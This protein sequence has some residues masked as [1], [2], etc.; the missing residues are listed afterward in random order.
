MRSIIA[1]LTLAFGIGLGG[2]ATAQTTGLQPFGSEAELKIWLAD[3]AAQEPPVQADCPPDWEVC[4][5]NRIDEVVVT[6][7]RAPSPTI[8]NNQEAGVDEGDIVKL[9]GDTLVILR[10]GR[11]FTVD[12][13]QGGLRP[14]ESIAAYAPGVEA[15][16]DWYDEMLVADGWVVVIGYSYERETSEINRFRLD[17]RGRL[18]FVDSH[19]LT[20]NDYYSSRNYASRLI[21]NRLVLYSPM[22]IGRDYDLM[23]DAPRLTRLR[24]D[25]QE[26][27]QPLLDVGDIYRTPT[28]IAGEDPEAEV[29][30]TLV[31]CDLTARVLACRGTAIVGPE[32][33]SVYVA[34]EAAYLWVSQRLWDR[35]D[36]AMRLGSAVYRIPLDG[37]APQMAH[38][39]GG[40]IDQLSFS[41]DTDR[42][43]LNVLVTAAASG[44]GMWNSEFRGGEAALLTLPLSRFSEGRAAP[45]EAD[46]RR[47]G[48]L[49]ENAG[50]VQ[51]RFVGRQLLY[52]VS[53]GWWNPETQASSVTVVPLDGGGITN[54]LMAGGVE[55]I[56]VMGRDALV[57]V[58]T[59]DG[60]SFN[61]VNL[62]D[63]E[64]E[65]YGPAPQISDTF[66]LADT[67]GAETR[68][69]A[70]FYQPAVDSPD[71]ER[72]LLGL[73]VM[74]ES[75][76]DNGLFDASADMA[77]L[78]RGNDRLAL[79][80]LLES[81]PD[82]QADD[83][84]VASCVDWYGDARPI[85]IGDRIFA[86]LGYELVEGRPEGR[87]LRE[88]NR[89]SFAPVIDD[90]DH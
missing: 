1:G 57:V 76:G 84:C 88:V 18:R 20:A 65:A 55:R 59:G 32:W 43:V 89:I 60:V 35:D 45:V 23:S 26:A 9:S 6:G 4:P 71:G 12:I 77:F 22:S 75:E 56:E 81:H 52:A 51:N 72:G 48:G 19:R 82:T 66:L 62:A 37:A 25:G 29:I 2:A 34:D 67:Y 80:G 87:T 24:A 11:L 85:F 42:G 41:E 61:T 16:D 5:G 49:P 28:L 79:Q 53:N 78:R 38:T 83:N 7:S 54:W 3:N 33:R 39:W 13:S 8:A 90:A 47:L 17:R 30:H 36:R 10:R 74:Q 46:Y 86:L 15:E 14:V 50:P 40:P 44:D 68:S 27:E 70:F 69:H 64:T 21:G 58:R 63:D 73:P 31:G